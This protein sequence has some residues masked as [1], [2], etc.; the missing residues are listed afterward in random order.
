MKKLNPSEN[1]RMRIAELKMEKEI[2]EKDLGASFNSIM[3]GLN[4]ISIAKNGL[5]DLAEDGD[6]QAGATGAALKFGTRFLAFKV[7]GRFGG[8][9]GAVA[10]AVVENLS[11][12]YVQKNTPKVLNAVGRFFK[13]KKHPEN[14]ETEDVQMH[15]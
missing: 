15:I 13:K 4:P 14:I 2:Q 5:Q 12:Q 3:E 6:I 1:L 9:F 11:D 10:A 8:V 7:I